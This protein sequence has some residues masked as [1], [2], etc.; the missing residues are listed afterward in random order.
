MLMS[1]MLSTHLRGG[2]NAIHLILTFRAWPLTTLQYLVS[3]TSRSPNNVDLTLLLATSVD[4]ERLFSRGRL[5]LSHVRSRLSAQSTRA[6]LCLGYW[7]RLNLVRTEDVTQV[8]ALPDVEG[9]EEEPEDG[10]DRIE[11]G[12]K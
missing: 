5:L 9:D 2:M 12:P 8:S 11:V 3:C 10:W 6:L 7:S 1:N 4:V